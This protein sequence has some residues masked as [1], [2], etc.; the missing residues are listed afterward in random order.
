MPYGLNEKT[1]ESIIEVFSHYPKIEK[2]I[3]Y[4]SR[5]KGTYKKGSDIDIAL[6]GKNL[7]IKELNQIWIELDDLMLPYQ[8]DL[9]L[10]NILSNDEFIDHIDRVGIEIYSKNQ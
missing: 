10:Y 5:A 4:G 7:N 2:A 9:T 1:L 8:F 6:V 3:L